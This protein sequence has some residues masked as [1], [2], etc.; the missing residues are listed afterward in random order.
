MNRM[1]DRPTDAQPTSFSASSGPTA[2]LGL[3]PPLIIGCALFMQTLD[4]TV[5]TNALPT[6][7]RSLRQ[8]PLTLNL[9]ITVY[10][11]ASAVFLPI[12]GW[13]ADRF[14]AKLVFRIAIAGFA[15]SSLLC[16]LSQSL[17][18][19]IGAR[20]VQGMAGAMM[21]PVARLIVVAMTPREQLVSAMN[22]FTMQIGRAH[23]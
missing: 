3:L 1:A 21:T 14:G 8:D 7:A 15:A 9:A 6:M 12:S 23:V 10:L 22:I 13:I 19:L 20:F 11:L 2:S 17:P 5:I 16:G 4:A 18:E